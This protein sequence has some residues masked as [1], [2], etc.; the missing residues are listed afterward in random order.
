MSMPRPGQPRIEGRQMHV[1]LL[2]AAKV[3]VRDL[4][5][6]LG[7]D[8]EPNARPPKVDFRKQR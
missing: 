4:D 5:L 8:L 6:N 1:P 7:P 2:S 3:P